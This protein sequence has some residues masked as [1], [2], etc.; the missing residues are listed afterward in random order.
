MCRGSA[1]MKWISKDISETTKSIGVSEGEGWE[2][3]DGAEHPITFFRRVAG[4][5]CGLKRGVYKR[6]GS[7]EISE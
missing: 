1:C 2:R 7:V 3:A 5:D 6:V 4:G